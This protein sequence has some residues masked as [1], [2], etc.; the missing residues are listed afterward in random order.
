LVGYR[1]YAENYTENYRITDGLYES[2]TPNTFG[3]IS[4]STFTLPT[5][6]GKSDDIS[7]D[8]FNDFR[9]NRLI[10]AQR[11][12]RERGADPNAVDADGYPLGFG[13]TSQA[14]L[15]PAFVSAYTGQKAEKAKLGAIK[16][17]PIPNWDI[18]YT[19]LMKMKWF[20]ERFKRFSLSH[21]YRSS[22]TIN[23]FR[24]NKVDAFSLGIFFRLL[25]NIVAFCLG[26]GS[27]YSC[28]KF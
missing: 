13:K 18:K 7:S 6:F 1:T 21:G 4:I 19:G 15:L 27:I 23:Q 25:S 8:A 9:S 26:L 10:I 12:A 2:L 3:N 5:A 22:Y 28:L 16:N 17:V 20:K 14:V 11:L 24:T